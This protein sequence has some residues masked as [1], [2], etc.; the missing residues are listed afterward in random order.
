MMRTI[1][2]FNSKIIRKS[3]S[4]V[5]KPIVTLD[6][7]V[8]EDL[9]SEVFKPRHHPG[10]DKAKVVTVPPRIV[11]SI[12]K[13]LKDAPVKGVYRDAQALNRYLKGRHIPPEQ[14][15]VKYKRQMIA[16]KLSQT[17]DLSDE[18]KQ[19][20]YDAKVDK[21]LKSQIYNWEPMVY[22]EYK[23]L[24]YVLGRSAQ[25]Y[26][27]VLRIFTEIQN[28]D[29]TFKPRSYFD[30]GSGVGTG[31]WAASKLWKDSIFEYFMVDSSRSMNDLA[32]LILRDGDENIQMELRNVNFRQFFP[33]SI[34]TTYD[35][36]I[37]A[38]SLFEL[39]D[40]QARL[41]TILSLWNRCESYLVLVE[42]GT[43][44]GFK[45]INEARD[46]ILHLNE[47]S[48]SGPVG[49]IFAPCAHNMTC[50]RLLA[51]DRS[52]CNFVTSYMPLP[53]DPEGANLPQ[54]ELYSYVV[55]KKGPNTDCDK[56]PRIV[57]PTLIRSKHAICRMCT[58][59]G[60][61]QEVI[62]TQSKHGKLPYRCARSSKWGDRLPIS[63]DAR[64]EI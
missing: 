28:R 53:L 31:L 36:V 11:S 21:T 12:F 43:M 29:P 35:I 40:T 48:E 8:A 44:A 58:K 5:Q 22:D 17:M 54:K 59:D 39:P 24:Q 64:T 26:S 50:P 45:L 38:Y 14:N 52:P 13:S 60:N 7:K 42:N 25:E 3:Y 33:A 41:E 4:T 15:L 47:K 56:W 9:E 62:F 16:D 57:R 2:G 27:T 61:L 10:T 19:K 34:E 23:A 18:K 30:F 49:H 63:I 32:D 55:L 20:K 6:K 37:S 46:F 1:C 51:D